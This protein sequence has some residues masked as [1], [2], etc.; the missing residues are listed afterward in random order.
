LD[1]PQ[2]VTGDAMSRK[3][4][5]EVY[6]VWWEYLKRSED[7]K[8]LCLWFR[9]RRENPDLHVPDKFKN[10]ASKSIQPI[11]STYR[12]FFHIHE[13]SFDEW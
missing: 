13:H 10:K 3:E 5:K 4:E 6:R 8:E 7:Y 12:K 2:G 1:H 11:D 9:G